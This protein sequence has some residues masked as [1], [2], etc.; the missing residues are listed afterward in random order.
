MAYRIVPF[1]MTL[2]DS[3][4]HS[5]VAGLKMEFVGHLC[6]ILHDFNRHSALG[7]VLNDYALHKSMHSLTHSASRG[8]SATTELLVVCIIRISQYTGEFSADKSQRRIRLS[9]RPT[10]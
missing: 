4:G 1:V 10:W 5:A 9:A 2:N 6:Q 3:E 7:G 8:P